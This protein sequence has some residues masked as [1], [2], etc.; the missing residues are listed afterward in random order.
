MQATFISPG[1][2]CAII[3]AKASSSQVRAEA[4]MSRTLKIA[5]IVVGVLIVL[6]LIVPFLI[7]V[8]QFKPTIESKASEALG[9]KIT[10]GNLSLSLLGG[11]LSAED[12][13]I[14]DDPKFSSSPFL[15]AKSVKVGVEVLPLIF[16]RALHVTGIAIDNPQVSLIRGPNGQWNYSSLGS[17]GGKSSAASNSQKTNSSSGT[18]DVSVGTFELKNGSVTVSSTGSSKRSVYDNV[19]VRASNLALAA[20]F[21]LTITAA[22]PAGG[23][24]KLDGTVGPVDSS[25]AVLTPLNAKLSIGSLNLASTGFLDASA[26]LGGIFDLDATL[27]SQ[28]GEA[29]VQGTGKLTKALL[30]AGGSPASVP[31][32]IEFHVKYDLRKNS[33]VLEPSTVK[34]GGAAS[35]LSG[36]FQ[37]PPEG[38]IVNIKVAGQSM[39]LKDLQSFLPALGV[40]MPN[41]ASIE[42][43]TLST[44]L[45]LAGPTAKLVTTGNVAVNSAKLKGFDLGSKMAAASS[46]L[47]VKTG[48]D[49]EIE[50]MTTNVRMAPEGLKADN[51]N[52]VLPAFG[53]LVGAGTLDAKNNLDFK[54]VA[55]L[56]SSNT[57][58]AGGNSGAGA[59]GGILGKVGGG[60]KGGLA[61]PFQIQGTTA[62]PKF[63]PDVGGAAA[64]MF[65]SQLGCIGKLVPGSSQQN[66]N[67]LDGLF[68]K[69]Q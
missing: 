26:G 43:G 33:G 63:I 51:F 37:A 28:N 14:A 5:A 66:A 65:K 27:A 13:S 31:L 7:P 4:S 22:L 64:G 59:L 47:G 20:K 8:N 36:T 17:A 12:L 41:G 58:A 11:S 42:A 19:N 3:A 44:N 67:P 53:T 2:D 40:N 50:K 1:N 52:A 69:K 32:T 54:M 6:L 45:D 35:Q 55:T 29:G 48:N 68:K 56:S 15:A 57:P 30:V 18:P 25:D 39:P 46:M 9:R 60:C 24:F 62:N 23:Q 49:L 34:I 10:L 61:V 16:S 38:A 21:P